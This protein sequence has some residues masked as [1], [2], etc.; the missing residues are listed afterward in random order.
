V[1]ADRRIH[2][3]HDVRVRR[4]SDGLA[5]S[6]RIAEGLQKSKPERHARNP[7]LSRTIPTV[8]QASRDDRYGPKPEAEEICQI[9]GPWVLWLC[10]PTVPLHALTKMTKS[11][12]S[13]WEKYQAMI[14]R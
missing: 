10:R 3:A 8:Q 12:P 2:R 6:D 13:R 5:T 7:S 4:L 11:Y 9:Y 1:N 14:E